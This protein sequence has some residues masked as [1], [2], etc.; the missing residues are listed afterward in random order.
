V[1]IQKAGDI[2]P[3]VV[4]VVKGL[5]TG[6]EK[7]FRMPEKCP[8][9]EAPIVRRA[10]EVASYCPSQNCFAVELRRLAH[11]TEKKAFDIEGLGPNKIKQLAEAGL[12]SDLADIFELKKGDLEPLDRFGEKSADNL[13]LSIEESRKVSLVRFLYALGIRHVGE[14]MAVALA[15]HVPSLSRL[16]KASPEE[17]EAVED[18]GPKVAV[19]IVEY[20]RAPE[21]RAL[22]D[23][24]FRAGVEIKEEEKRSHRLE[25]KSFV[26]TGSLSGYS[27]DEAKELIRR[28]G[29]EV[30][31]SVTRETD[32]VIAGE[33]AGSKLAKAEKL[34]VKVLNE[35]DFLKMAEE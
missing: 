26:L 34:G 32:Y 2:I 23:K 18:V 22:L 14:V 33:K 29:G 5:R 6:A 28:Q 10:G 19:S 12:I 31:A 20:F 27:R 24:L 11:A 1:V 3:E 7:K 4:S 21:N 8:Y 17:L 9:C 35:E 25:G 13:L 15:R 30:H 16:E